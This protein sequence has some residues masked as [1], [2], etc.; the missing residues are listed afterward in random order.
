MAYYAYVHVR[1]GADVT[2]VF[3]VGK[4]KG[5]RAWDFGRRNTYHAHITEKYGAQNIEVSILECSDEATAFELEAGLIKCLRRSGVILTN[6]TDGGEGV[7]GLRHSHEARAQMSAA[8]KGRKHSSVTKAKMSES[9]SGLSNPFYG[10]THSEETKRRISDT[11]KSAPIRYW[12]GKPKSEEVRKKISDSLRGKMTGFKHT[13][14]TRAKI[15]LAQKGKKR[16]PL[17][18][19]TRAKLS[20]SVKESWR[21]RKQDINGELT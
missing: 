2:G 7:S 3:Y 15:S 18:V 12:L 20:A 5:R 14:E 4:G 9:R 8:R 21:K 10:K 19:E 16:I 13:D 6:T 11:K 17:S 1:P